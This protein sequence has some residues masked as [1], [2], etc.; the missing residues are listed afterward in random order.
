MDIGAHVRSSGGLPAALA[1]GREIRADVIQVFTQSPRMWRAA[2]HDAETLARVRAE[3]AVGNRL[4]R[5]FCHA[6]YLVNLATPDAAL[7]ERSRTCLVDNLTTAAAIGADGL[8]L[9][10]GSHLGG[11]FAGCRDQVAQSLLA[12]LE[13]TE[14]V[15]GQP[16]CP[17]LLENAA[18]AGGTVGRSFAELAELIDATGGDARLGVCLDTQHLFASGVAYDTLEKADQVVADIEHH[19]GLER[20]ACLHVND[21]AVPLGANRDRHANLGE[22]EIG[23][24][25]LSLLLGHPSLETCAAILEVPGN[26]DGPRDLDVALARRLQQAGTSHFAKRNARGMGRSAGTAR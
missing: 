6:T 10:V 1:R 23:E 24:M 4:R 14:E 12:V 21:S 9:H 7:L 11:G 22:G 25:A 19:V 26:G 20:L 5:V 8:V 15:L 18:G 3:I 2:R 16:G 13:E 17:I